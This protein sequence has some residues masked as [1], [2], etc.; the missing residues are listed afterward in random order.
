M[1]SRK[2]VLGVYEVAPYLS[3]KS[4]AHGPHRPRGFMEDVAR[5]VFIWVMRR[6]QRP[7]CGVTMRGAVSRIVMSGA[8]RVERAML[9]QSSV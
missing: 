1:K 7:P 8:E 5:N 9:G 4:V 3:F 6:R 2:S